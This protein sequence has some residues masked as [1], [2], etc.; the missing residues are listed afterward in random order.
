MLGAHAADNCQMGSRGLT[1]FSDAPE[2][3][4]VAAGRRC[5]IVAARQESAEAAFRR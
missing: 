3:S 2:W 1:V 4:S 5:R